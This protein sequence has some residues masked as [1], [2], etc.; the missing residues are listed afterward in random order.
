MTGCGVSPEAVYQ[1]A[2]NVFVASSEIY[3][4]EA[5][6]NLAMQAA[7]EHGLVTCDRLRGSAVYF[8]PQRS[9]T[10]SAG[11]RVGGL[12]Y[13]RETNYLNTFDKIVV[14]WAEGVRLSETALV[15][16]WAHVGRC[17]SDDHE[18]WP[19]DAIARANAFLRERGE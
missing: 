14:G 1:A 12:A 17:P 13:C 9:W 18:D 6:V 2:C 16:E 8:F 5:H 19:T 3:P 10:D 11:R 15:H 7:I 4:S